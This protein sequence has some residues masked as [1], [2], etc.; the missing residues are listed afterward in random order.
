LQLTTRQRAKNFSGNLNGVQISDR[1]RAHQSVVGDH[2][3]AFV[4]A[5]SPDSNGMLRAAA[6]WLT[7]VT[8]KLD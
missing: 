8:T 1:A 7:P 2:D 3:S 4:A 6:C 5:A